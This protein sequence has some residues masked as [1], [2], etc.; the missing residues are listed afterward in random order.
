[1]K[2]PWRFRLIRWTR[3]LRIWL[4]GWK[5]MERRH[6]LF[7][8]S[9]PLTPEQICERL[10]RHGW[11]YNTMSHTYRGQRFTVR[12]PDPP[13]HQ[14]H[15]RFYSDGRVSGHYEVDPFIF[16]LEHLDG[17]DLRALNNSE[18][19]E[20]MMELEYPELRIG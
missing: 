7:T 5:E 4:G 16:P 1:M 17:V 12:R 18:I 19:Y 13:R 2:G 20:L 11:G 10:W 9:Q 15:L 14:W 8:H 6:Y 3:Q